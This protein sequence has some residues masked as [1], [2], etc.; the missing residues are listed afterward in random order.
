MAV[1]FVA[2]LVYLRAR[3]GGNPPLATVL[4]VGAA[5]LAAVLVGRFL[6]VHGKILG[7]LTIALVGIV[8]LGVL[9]A[10]GEFGAADR[11]KFARVLRR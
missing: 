10:A 2:S 4:R 3:L 5:A 1:G 9:V 11:A 8:Y 7:L 6:P